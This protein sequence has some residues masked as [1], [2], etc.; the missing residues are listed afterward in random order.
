[1]SLNSAGDKNQVLNDFS[2]GHKIFL[3]IQNILMLAS[4]LVLKC[5]KL[6]P[7]FNV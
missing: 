2:G 5:L 4:S 7:D 6:D 3:C 1:M